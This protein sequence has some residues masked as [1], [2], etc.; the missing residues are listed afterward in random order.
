MNLKITRPLLLVGCGKMGSAMLDGWLN[1]NIIE[2]DIIIIDPHAPDKYKGK[3]NI[4]IYDNIDKLND[5]LNPQIIILATKPQ[6]IDKSIENFKKFTGDDTLFISIIA[7]KTIEYFTKKLGKDI[8]VIRAMPNT[9]AAISQGITVIYANKNVNTGQITLGHNLLST[10]G[11]VEIIDD[12]VMMDAVT[13]LSGGGPAYIFHMINSMAKAGIEQGLPI[14]LAEKL[15]L[16][17][18][19]GSGQLA[20]NSDQHPDKLLK[21]VTSPNGTTLAA[22]NILEN[23]CDNLQGLMIKAIA[24]ASARSKELSS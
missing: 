9:P 24:A 12:E 15:A 7:G 4:K 19:A 6:Q 3:N 14:E 5:N 8:K 2:N 22:M 17:T 13:A 1:S 11:I 16:I 10:I 21:N 23:E 18:V 20:L